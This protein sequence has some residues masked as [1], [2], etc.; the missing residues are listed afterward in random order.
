MKNCNHGRLA[1][2]LLR[3]Q[4]QLITGSTD[5]G[6]LEREVHCGMRQMTLPF[7]FYLFLQAM[8]A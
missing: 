1:Q 7:T 3:E 4:I 5:S 6:P 2:Q 8:S